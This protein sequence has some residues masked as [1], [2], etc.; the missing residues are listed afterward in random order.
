MSQ[1]PET[2]ELH[3]R[4]MKERLK[5][6]HGDSMTLEINDSLPLALKEKFLASI[7]A[8]EEAEELPLFDYLVENGVSLPAPDTLNDIQIISAT[9][10]YM[11]CFGMTSCGNLPASIRRMPKHSPILTSSAVAA[12]K[13][14]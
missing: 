10:N 6:M 5:K 12:R 7:I 11:K 8:M 3:I 2:Q 9:A 1:K 13:I 14:A 4:E